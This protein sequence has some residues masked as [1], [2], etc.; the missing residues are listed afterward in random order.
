M[1][2][3]LVEIPARTGI[4]RSAAMSPQAVS[5]SHP[6]PAADLVR[7]AIPLVLVAS[8][9]AA[10]LWIERSPEAGATRTAAVESGSR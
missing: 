10:T 2:S 4:R 1:G 8:A 3:K 5:T 7:L 9:V 6:S